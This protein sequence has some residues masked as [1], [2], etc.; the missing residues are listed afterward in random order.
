MNYFNTVCY[1]LDVYSYNFHEMS[2]FRKLQVRQNH[3]DNKKLQLKINDFPDSQFNRKPLQLAEKFVIKV[4]DKCIKI[5]ENTQ[6]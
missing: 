2:L 5:Q 3:F 1:E 6:N 4:N